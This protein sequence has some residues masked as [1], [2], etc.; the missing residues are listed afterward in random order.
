MVV[1]VTK[2]IVIAWVLYSFTQS[3]KWTTPGPRT[4]HSTILRNS[5]LSELSPIPKRWTSIRTRRNLCWKRRSTLATCSCWAPGRC[6]IKIHCPCYWTDFNFTSVLD[7][8]RILF[9]W[10][11]PWLDVL[12]FLNYNLWSSQ[13]TIPWDTLAFCFN[14]KF[15]VNVNI[16]K[17][18]LCDRIHLIAALA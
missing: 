13:Y 4:R 17:Q 15:F 2:K 8:W 3:S 7:F 16:F 11:S 5:R 14:F 6:R 12:F 9:S 1:I 18:I 10:H